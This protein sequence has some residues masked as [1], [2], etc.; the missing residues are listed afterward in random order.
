PGRAALARHLRGRVLLSCP[1]SW[2]SRTLSLAGQCRRPRHAPA[3]PQGHRRD[4][5]ARYPRDLLR[6]HRLRQ[7]RPPGR[8]RDGRALR[9][10]PLRRLAI[11]AGR[12]GT[13]L[14]GPA[15]RHCRDDRQRPEGGRRVVSPDDATRTSARAGAAAP[16]G[17]RA[18]GLTVTY[19]NGLTALTDA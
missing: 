16:P 14:S 9:R 15:A 10:R 4:P 8:A 11:G 1:R 12:P 5:R 6:E 19:R 7:A 2:A 3:G 17:I 18:E 13:D